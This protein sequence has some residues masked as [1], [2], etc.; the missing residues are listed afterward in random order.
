M[1][2]TL[3]VFLSCLYF[4]MFLI[5]LMAF[6]GTLFSNDC[7]RDYLAS[8][9]IK[10][11]IK[12]FGFTIIAFILTIVFLRPCIFSLSDNT[13]YE[14][15]DLSSKPYATEYLSSR[16]SINDGYCN[17]SVYD[18]KIG[19]PVNRSMPTKV[20]TFYYKNIEKPYVEWYKDSSHMMGMTRE[21]TRIKLYLPESWRNS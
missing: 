20:S 13:K 16:V 8:F 9:N 21:R 1:S 12:G 19:I 5:S 17:F 2:D 4:M 3:S 14:K 6:L 10:G 7:N 15:Y 11:F 18:Y